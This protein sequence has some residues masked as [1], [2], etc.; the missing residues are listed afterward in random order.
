MG[1][2]SVS[3]PKR[4]RLRACIVLFASDLR[5][6]VR[7]DIIKACTFF[8]VTSDFWTAQMPAVKSILRFTTEADG[9][10]GRFAGVKKS[11]GAQRRAR[12]SFV[13]KE[14]DSISS[15]HGDD[16]GL[17]E[18]KRLDT[19]RLYDLAIDEILMLQVLNCWRWRKPQWLPCAKLF[20]RFAPSL[21][22]A[23]R[24]RDQHVLFKVC[25]QHVHAAGPLPG[26]PKCSQ[27]IHVTIPPF[28]LSPRSRSDHAAP[29]P[30]TTA[31]LATLSQYTRA[32]FRRRG[33]CSEVPPDIPASSTPT[34]ITK[35]DL[36]S[37]VFRPMSG[38]RE[39]LK[40]GSLIPQSRYKRKIR[41]RKT[42]KRTGGNA[43]DGGSSGE[44]SN[45]GR[46]D[47]SSQH[48][49]ALSVVAGSAFNLQQAKTDT[50]A[51]SFGV[52]HAMAGPGSQVN[53][54]GEQSSLAAADTAASEPR[55]ER[56]THFYQGYK[57]TRS[58]ASSRKTS[59]RC[60]KSRSAHRLHG[61][62]QCAPAH[63]P[64]LECR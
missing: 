24:R 52:E 28:G 46:G 40:D 34:Q 57:Y 33:T 31:R 47:I 35:C 56:T 36:N 6:E 42:K 15:E 9:G 4:N 8:S 58:W 44:S 30:S 16:D 62:L 37:T 38:D 1:K 55:Q 60:S 10:A 26:P 3:I 61:L 43:G 22:F 12:A 21:A 27:R 2:V 41:A 20:S 63:A 64:K 25:P 50:G 11:S 23:G 48:N 29:A 39:A 59:F 45:E 7:D 54:F 14:Q 19:E 17:S 53:I 32:V 18:N 5:A 51:G 13:D 49:R